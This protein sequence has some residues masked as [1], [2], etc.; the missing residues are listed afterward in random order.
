[1]C[2]LTS[3]ESSL[4]SNRAFRIRLTIHLSAS[5]GVIF[6]LS[7]NILKGKQLIKWQNKI[8][9]V[10]KDNK[11]LWNTSQTNTK[12]GTVQDSINTA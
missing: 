9:D 11:G 8:S 1:M 4:A 6:S 7:A 12:Y 5:S 10:G 2:S 3:L